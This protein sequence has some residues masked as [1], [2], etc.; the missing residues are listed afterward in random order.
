LSES[1]DAST[2]APPAAR[3]G[4]RQVALALGLWALLAVAVALVSIDLRL[5]FYR[6]QVAA[7]ATA[8]LA[9]VQDTLAVA[10][11]Q[12]RAIAAELAQRRTVVEF[13]ARPQAAELDDARRSTM[14]AELSSVGERFRLPFVA[15]I[16][17]AG[18]VLVNTPTGN[19]AASTKGLDVSDRLYVRQALAEGRGTRFVLGRVSGVPGLYF[20]DRI[21]QHGRVLGVAVVKQ[22]AEVINRLLA[23]AQQQ[24]ILLTDPNG[25]VVLGNRDDAML[26]RLDASAPLPEASARPLYRRMPEPLGWVREALAA[27]TGPVDAVQIDAM[28]HVIRQAALPGTPLTARVLSPLGDEAAIRSRFV[29]GLAA[30][31]LMGSTLIGFAWWRL[32]WS[33]RAL[34]AQ[35]DTARLTLARRASDERF[36]AVYEHAA[37]A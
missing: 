9:A 24:T 25:V 19:G 21:E 27:R 17:P 15:L 22:D 18:R 10:L 35:H 3:L 30:L 13:A 34:D 37:T 28:R 32:R 26:R 20:A 23:D 1:L 31:W 7:S 5:R 36:S 33:Q 4:E 6:E 11:Q 14:L 16:E 29:A 12:R 2:P 8:R